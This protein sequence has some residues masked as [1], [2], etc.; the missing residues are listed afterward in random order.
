MIEV[1]RFALLGLGPGAIYGLFGQGIVL[2]HRG[3]G[4]LN[5]AHGAMGMVS[6]FVFLDLWQG[7]GWPVLIALAAAIAFS[8]LLGA[9]THF[10]VMRPL[11][12]AS[13]VI[14]MI[15]TLGVLTVLQEAANIKWGS[16]EQLVPQFLPQR[17]LRPASTL[18]IGEDRLILLGIAIAL[19]A[20]LWSVY[21]YSRFGK[22]TAAVVENQRAATALG[23]SPNVISLVNW[24]LGAAL[25][26]AAGC[27]LAPLSGVQIQTLT[28][29]VIP[30]LA[31]A[32]IGGFES[33]PLTLL[34][35]I[36]LG[37]IESEAA[38]YV[39]TPGIARSV[40]FV[41]ITLVIVLRGR[42]LPVRGFLAE[43]LPAVGSGQVRPITLAVVVATLGIV[44]WLAFP[45]TWLEAG[46]TMLATAITLLSLVV[47]I[48]YAG[49]LSL[50]QYALAGLGALIA[51]RLAAHGWPF[52]LALV[53]GVLGSV[54][55]G[56]LFA[57]PALRARGVHLAVI[58]LGLG[59]SLFL[60]ILNNTTYTGYA[61]DAQLGNMH[62][63]FWN[64]DATSQPLHY[65]LFVLGA[66]VVA[67]LAISNVRRGRAGRR[68]IAVRTNERAAA[69]LGINVLG[70]KLYAFGLAASVA[71]LGGICLGF[72]SPSI[73]YTD[74]Y[75]VFASITAVL[76][77]VIGGVG[78][79]AGVLFG[80]TFAKGGLGTL[81]NPLIGGFDRYIGLVSGLLLLAVLRVN[82]HGLA[83]KHVEAVHVVGRLVF[84]HRSR[85]ETRRDVAGADAVRATMPALSPATLEIDD[86]TVRFGGVVA[87]Q[88]V[89]LAVEP[90][91]V[92]GLMGPNGAGKTTLVDAATGFVRPSSGQVRLGGERIDQL[93][94][95][96]RARRG[97]IRSFQGLELFEDVT[98]RENL[99]AASDGHEWSALLTDIV[100]PHGAALPPVTAAAVREFGLE[101]DLDRKPEELSYG[102]RRLVGIARAIVAA[103]SVLLL[104]EPAAGLS[105]SER[106]DL[107]A[108]LR[109][110]ATS[111]GIGILVIEHDTA[112]VLDLCDRVVVLDF[113]RLIADG[114]PAQVRE[115]PGVRTAYL[116]KPAA[117]VAHPGVGARP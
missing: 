87:V 117:E 36:I 29:M 7:S 39:S 77:A 108:M 10:F 23:W 58:T 31:A 56:L 76:M 92:V 116:G 64:I 9:A 13:A 27:L 19:T 100:W 111:W 115:D 89:S 21:R 112:F 38:R 109:Q 61:Q 94:A 32:L 78:Y 82:P 3:A 20:T 33:F 104:D 28:L 83:L 48:G 51:A 45:T 43:R 106:H 81:I 95:Y 66:M 15:A 91:M 113:G 37:I 2:V 73:V 105:Q 26:G 72:R 107:S 93:P 53:I 25:A 57:L 84:R 101:E 4:V 75:D 69:A 80:M 90:G 14:R 67:G 103:P 12:H 102:R 96:V 86:I 52:E 5:F 70:T 22:A 6:A 1:L 18:V 47:L 71:A 54:P 34:G 44:A 110:I 17:V 68:L 65:F 63:L 85:E 40:P 8:A 30:T 62:F 99:L 97:L 49:Q 74:L 41:V 98:V 88:S 60:V 11:Q 42:S 50:G 24:T 79:I 59:Y 46:T 16:E 55:I 35:G 114:T